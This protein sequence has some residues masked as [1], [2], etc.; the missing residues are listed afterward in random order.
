MVNT[1]KQEAIKMLKPE[2]II[3]WS[4]Q[5]YPTR[6]KLY[7]AIWQGA[8]EKERTRLKKLRDVKGASK[9]SDRPDIPWD[10]PSSETG[11]KCHVEE[12][13][14]IIR[15]DDY[16]RIQRKGKF[17]GK[18]RH[19]DCQNPELSLNNS[20]FK[21]QTWSLYLNYNFR[22]HVE[23]FP[24]RTSEIILAKQ[25][26]NGPD[27][28][29]YLKVIQGEWSEDNE[30]LD[31]DHRIYPELAMR[32]WEHGEKADEEGEGGSGSGEGEDP[33]PEETPSEGDSGEG[34]ESEETKPTP[35]TTPNSD[36]PSMDEFIDKIVAKVQ[37]KLGDLTDLKE[38]TD[39]AKKEISKEAKKVVKESLG[40]VERKPIRIEVDVKGEIE[41]IDLPH[42]RMPE[43]IEKAVGL[44]KHCYL[45][46]PPASGKSTACKKVAEMLKLD[47]NFMTVGQYTSKHD[48]EGFKTP[49]NEYADTPLAMSFRNGAV[50][51]MDEMDNATS[52]CLVTLNTMLANDSYSFPDPQNLTPQQAHKDFIFLGCGNS[53]GSGSSPQFPNRFRFDS[54]FS[55]RFCFIHWDYDR[56]QEQAITLHKAKQFGIDDATALEFLQYVWKVRDYCE[57]SHPEILVSPRT[58]FNGIEFLSLETMTQEKAMIDLVFKTTDESTARDILEYVGKGGNL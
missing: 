4:K 9:A 2:Q 44:R 31:R 57:N 19:Q 7:E 37:E 10:D 53:N 29:N 16:I 15:P 39:H 40:G 34:G 45:W 49:S 58:S 42:K 22:H 41:K 27:Y 12:C 33:R 3:K 23:L 36:D 48:L 43:L 52:N 20:A 54:S 50:F 21:Q 46:G 11:N 24:I 25:V 13:G 30:R 26:S 32:S 35:K 47:F 55:D 8:S 1:N 5:T 38:A 51:M 14:E 56:K 17:K 28:S 18:L 6:E